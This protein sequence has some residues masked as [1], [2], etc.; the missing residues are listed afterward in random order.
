MPDGNNKQLFYSM[1]NKR[2]LGEHFG[3]CRTKF[4]F[5]AGYNIGPDSHL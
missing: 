5:F 3:W 4:H 2:T 1:A